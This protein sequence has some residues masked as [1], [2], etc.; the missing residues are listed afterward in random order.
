MLQCLFDYGSLSKEVESKYINAI[1]GDL[2]KSLDKTIFS[3]LIETVVVLQNFIK[4]EVFKNESSLSLRDI[5]RVKK[6]FLFYCYFI[7]YRKHYKEIKYEKL[8]PFDE[9]I[10][11]EKLDF[12]SLTRNELLRAFFVSIAI[13]YLYRISHEGNA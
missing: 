4:S 6:V 1:F 3:M 11:K 9:F 12:E 8:L 10:L 7:K 2:E 5:K 13:N